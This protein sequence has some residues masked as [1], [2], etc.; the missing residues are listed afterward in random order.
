MIVGSKSTFHRYTSMLLAFSMLWNVAGW[1]GLG[2]I[3]FHVQA[4]GEGEHCE[5]SF[6]YCEIGDGQKICTCHHPELHVEKHHEGQ[7]GDEHDSPDHSS[8]DSEYCYFSS[9]HN[10]PYQTD[11]PIVLVKFNA[12]LNPVAFCLPV[13]ETNRWKQ[14]ND[15]TPFAGYMHDLFRPPMV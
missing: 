3:D 15:A 12:L 8:F 11:A 2:L 5:V 4:H 1:L 13:P 9:S 10:T 6:C 14:M 7:D